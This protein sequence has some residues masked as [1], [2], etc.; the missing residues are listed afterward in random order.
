VIN[1][2][3]GCVYSMFHLY[4]VMRTRQCVIKT[5]ATGMVMSAG[6]L[7][8]AGGD[9]GHRT[10]MENCQFMFHIGSSEI[11]D[12]HSNALS[13]FKHHEIV[14]NNMVK[15]IAKRT[16]KGLKFWRGLESK[17]VDQYFTSVK[18][19]TYGLADKI[20]KGK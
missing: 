13:T 14:K 19:K 7:L 12:E 16:G 5:V 6:I 10:A 1:T 18:A 2:P 15:A 4:D 3:G 8:F 20:S 17:V 9:K 11:A